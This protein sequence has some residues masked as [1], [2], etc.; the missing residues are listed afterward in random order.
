L[1]LRESYETDKAEGNFRPSTETQKKDES[2]KRF[3]LA[4]GYDMTKCMVDQWDLEAEAKDF[5]GQ[6]TLPE[7]LPTSGGISSV[8]TKRN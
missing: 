8:S 3:S 7:W 5:V 1:K 6:Q 4:T 2:Y